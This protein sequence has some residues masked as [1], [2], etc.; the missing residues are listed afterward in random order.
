[1]TNADTPTLAFRN[2]IERPVN[3]FTGVPVTDTPKNAGELMVLA[4]NWRIW[5]NNGNK[6]QAGDWLTLKGDNFFDM[7]AWTHL[8]I[9]VK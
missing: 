6:Y 5:Q 9:G 2:L 8:G 4:T 3:P 7:S 1:M